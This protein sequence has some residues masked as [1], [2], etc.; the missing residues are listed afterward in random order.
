MANDLTFT[1]SKMSSNHSFT[2]LQET[3]ET[4]MQFILDY[5]APTQ[6]KEC[7]KHVKLIIVFGGEKRQ[8][9]MQKWKGNC[10]IESNQT[11]SILAR[12]EG[13]LGG[14]DNSK[15]K[16]IRFNEYYLPN[17][18]ESDIYVRVLNTDEDKWTIEK[19]LDLKDAFVMTLNSRL[20]AKCVKG[21]I[22]IN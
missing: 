15:N 2:T 9:L 11:L 22:T 18:N 20:Q 10:K 17:E 16:Q 8:L 21:Y 5:D 4:K 6:L 19:L 14:D 13:G 7:W 3:R 1:D 12:C